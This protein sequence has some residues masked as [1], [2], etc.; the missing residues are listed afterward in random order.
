MPKVEFTEEEWIEIEALA[1][2]L[3]LNA[4]D[5]V[6]YAVRKTSEAIRRVLEAEGRK[7]GKKTVPRGKPAAPRSD[8][9][10]RAETDLSKKS[11]GLRHNPFEDALSVLSVEDLKPKK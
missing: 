9:V 11:S 3:G 6:R 7:R 5:L 2:C 8:R 1:M 4:D 10:Y